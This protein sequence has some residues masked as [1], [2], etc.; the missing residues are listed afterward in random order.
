MKKT[1]LFLLA[2]SFLFSGC[3]WM[4]GSY[5]SVEPY[6]ANQSRK[7]EGITSVSSYQEVRSALIQMVENVE[8]N[9]TLSL[10]DFNSDHVETNL[11]LAIQSVLSSNPVGAYAVENI[12]YELGIVG[13]VQ[14]V[15]MKIAYNHNRSEIKSLRQLSGMAAAK[16][17][18][19]GALE[20]LD[21]G[22]VFLVSGYRDM[23]FQQFVDDYAKENPDLVMEIPEVAVSQYPEY[24]NVRIVEMKFVYETS[25]DALKSMQSYVRPKFTAATMFI[26]GEDEPAVKYER[27]YSF[28]METAEYNLETSLTP[29]YSLLRHSVGDS[30]AFAT[31]YAAVCRRSG[32][33]C[34]IVTGTRSGESWNWNMVCLDGS[35]YHLDLVD[36]YL[37]G[38]YALRYDQD[39]VG[40]VWDY[41]TTPKSIPLIP[42]EETTEST[43]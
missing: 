2:L 10:V 22:V 38:S 28:L 7:E 11:K 35:W 29:A 31:I 34:R 23:D 8:D 24:G 17:L 16:N 4:G 32:L 27:L 1:L 13:G 42:S 9:R 20:R 21:S 43:E 5:A 19:T 37:C 39:M 36:C 12:T 15:V 41:A 26:S 30:K 18:I 25:R 33:D 14:A 40:Y 3:G 6:D